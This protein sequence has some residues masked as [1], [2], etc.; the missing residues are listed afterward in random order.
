VLAE[1]EIFLTS[2]FKLPHYA[3]PNGFARMLAGGYGTRDA[4]QSHFKFGVINVSHRDLAKGLLEWQKRNRT[5]SASGISVT[6]AN[7]CE[8]GYWFYEMHT[9]V[10]VQTCPSY[11]SF[12]YFSFTPPKITSLHRSGRESAAPTGVTLRSS[13]CLRFRVLCSRDAAVCRHHRDSCCCRPGI[14]LRILFRPRFEPL[15]W[16]FLDPRRAA[17]AIFF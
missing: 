3:L 10:P 13:F 8:K 7:P 16:V 12:A 5:Y 11:K 2:D 17:S 4:G 9:S 15:C 14:S 6:R 1:L